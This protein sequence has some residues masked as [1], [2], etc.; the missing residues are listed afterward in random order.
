MMAIANKNKIP[1]KASTVEK[2]NSHEIF[3]V[4]NIGFVSFYTKML[5]PSKLANLVE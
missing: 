4:V 2:Q 3:D 1:Q 5:K